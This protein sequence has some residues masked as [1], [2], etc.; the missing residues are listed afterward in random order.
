MQV[1]DADVA[2]VQAD[3]DAG[4]ARG[5]QGSPTFFVGNEGFFC[6]TLNITKVGDSLEIE[7]DR[8]AFD[9]FVTEVF[10]N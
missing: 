4:K 7:F 6:P 9:A 3:Y 10:A 5:V 8:D 2:Q 1:T